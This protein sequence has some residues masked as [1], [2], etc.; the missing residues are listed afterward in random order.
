MAFCGARRLSR[1]V[2]VRSLLE[3]AG[4]VDFQNVA[5]MRGGLRL[6]NVQSYKRKRPQRSKK[7]LYME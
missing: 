6:L 2:R 3:A 1:K 4:D 5:F 7:H